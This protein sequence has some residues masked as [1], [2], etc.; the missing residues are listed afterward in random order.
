MCLSV[1]DGGVHLG[2]VLLMCSL[3]GVFGVLIV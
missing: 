2:N 1:S 3:G